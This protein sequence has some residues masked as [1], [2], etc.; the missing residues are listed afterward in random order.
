VSVSSP[1]PSGL[2]FKAYEIE[3]L[4]DVYFFRRCGI[5]VAH[6][7]RAC[8]LS[9]NT[10][11]ILAGAIGVGGALLASE[12]LAPV[13]VA[14]L[15]L[16]GIFDSADGQLARMTGQTSELGR[17]L[18][19]LA[20]YV[21][22][23]AAYLG[24]VAGVIARGGSWSILGWAAAAGLFT[25]V[26]AQMY[27][28]HRTAYTAIVVKGISTRTSRANDRPSPPLIAGY[29]AVQRRLA[30]RHPEVEALIA[31]RS[32]GGQVR[33]D[34]RARY[35]ACFYRPVRG[36]N[37]LGDNVRRYAFAVLALVHHL[38]WM[39]PFI[40]LPLNLV[41]AAM[42]LWQRRADRRFLDATAAAALTA[43]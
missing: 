32:P 34:D 18:D 37:L 25:A 31:A 7:A 38:D 41:L 29:E 40:L 21:T 24:I 39:F 33:A 17:L 23:T 19:G 20:G 9:P 27:D 10:V 22:H 26:H 42:W 2:A 3:E 30:G 13:G 4:A 11:S 28:Y 12:R 35:R 14:C 43:P 1:G 5:V 36:W 6:A 15:F 16:Y 8:G